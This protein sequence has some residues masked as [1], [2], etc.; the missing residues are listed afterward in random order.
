MPSPFPGMDPYL[1]GFLWAD[2]HHRLAAE[3]AS[4]LTPQLDPR[5]VARVETRFVADVSG[6]IPRRVLY[7]DVDVTIAREIL[8][9]KTAHEAGVRTKPPV[10]APPLVLIQSTYPQIELAS[11]AIRDTRHNRLVASI[12]VLSP[13][14]KRGKG[15]VEYQQK[16]GY[17][18]QALAHLLEIDLLRTGRRPV[19]LARLPDDLSDETRQLVEDAAYFVFLTRGA[20]YDQVATW[21]IRLRDPLPVLPVPLDE[22]DPDIRLDL[23][24]ALRTIY[25]AAAY[26][27]SIDYRQPPEPPLTGDDA[28]WADAWLR[29]KGAR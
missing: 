15:F 19:S 21:P 7:P 18:I 14:N 24:A 25:D 6:D 4:Q 27:R 5:Y 16:R 2:V 9:V 3:I 13:V 22:P 12:E 11:V 8:E 20:Y 17:V 28:A 23:G 1:E 26:E 10:D 29:E